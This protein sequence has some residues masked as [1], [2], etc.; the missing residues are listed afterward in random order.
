MH[1]QELVI[2]QLVRDRA[3]A[4]TREARSWSLASRRADRRPPPSRHQIDGRVRWR[5]RLSPAG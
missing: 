5:R 1:T 4:F 2:G 3:D